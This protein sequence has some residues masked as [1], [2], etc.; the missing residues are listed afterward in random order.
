MGSTFASIHVYDPDRKLDA[1]RFCQ[2]YLDELHDIEKECRKRSRAL[3]E[4]FGEELLS[5]SQSTLRC[6]VEEERE[7]VTFAEH[8]EWHSA[9]DCSFTFETIEEAARL[10]SQTV[11]APVFYAAETD[12]DI[13][14]FGV[15][16]AG[17]IATRQVTG[18]CFALR[19]YGIE[20]RCADA[21]V[22]CEQLKLR[23]RALAEKLCRQRNVG[24]ARKLIETL[25]GA[26]ICQG[27]DTER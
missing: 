25:L 27:S 17:R 15:S 18:S 8:G 7:E 5:D 6:V 13:L 23:D 10:L 3:H 16:V 20:R 14:W 22:L 19:G 26:R 1:G 9:Y 11:D 12:G 21:Q 4:L 24:R 2:V